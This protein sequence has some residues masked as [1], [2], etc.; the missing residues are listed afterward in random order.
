ME[1]VAIVRENLLLPSIK[2]V[3][4]IVQVNNEQIL[5]SVRSALVLCDG[6]VS[7]GIER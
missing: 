3:G 6:S 4:I 1:Y 5:A 2:I 7:K